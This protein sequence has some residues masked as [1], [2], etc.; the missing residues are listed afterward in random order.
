MIKVIVCSEDLKFVSELKDEL[1]YLTHHHY[2]E[3]SIQNFMSGDELFNNIKTYDKNMLIFID[4]SML[5]TKGLLTAKHMR[6]IFP[7]VP[8]TL[9]SNNLNYVLD[10]Y[11]VDAK[12]YLL[13]PCP[14]DI[15]EETLFKMLAE[16][17][18]PNEMLFYYKVGHKINTIPFSQILYYESERRIIKII[19]TNG[20]VIDFYGK[21][22]DVE[23]MITAKPFMR[24]HRSYL[25]NPD[26]LEKIERST[27]TLVTG[28]KIPVSRAKHTDIK[29]KFLG[30]LQEMERHA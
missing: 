9:V 22:D 15:L 19:K 12:N 30:Y 14:L 3:I 23:K 6:R 21:L 2:E 4:L 7:K 16:I 10:G 1:K 27:L 20:Q 29:R 5:N 13:K 24:S 18:T 17:E 25:V 28:E 8:M 26:Y 11:R